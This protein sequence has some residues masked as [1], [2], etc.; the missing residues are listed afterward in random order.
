MLKVFDYI[1]ES[2]NKNENEF[3]EIAGI[4]KLNNETKDYNSLVISSYWKVLEIKTLQI[5]DLKFKV[6]FK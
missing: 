2:Y 1:L 6:S 3:F 5:S 4:N